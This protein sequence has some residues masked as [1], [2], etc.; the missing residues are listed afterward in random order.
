ME[1]Q[2]KTKSCF[3]ACGTQCHIITSVCVLGDLHMPTDT[4]GAKLCTSF[5]IFTFVPLAL[6]LRI[7]SHLRSG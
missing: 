7:K 4:F 3:D 1:W 5:L 2:T 6:N